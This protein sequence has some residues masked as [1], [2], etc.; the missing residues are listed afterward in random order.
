LDKLRAED[1]PEGLIIP[2]ADSAMIE[3]CKASFPETRLQARREHGNPKY[4]PV[5][6]N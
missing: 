5:G 4:A 3:P 1:E 2:S 6:P